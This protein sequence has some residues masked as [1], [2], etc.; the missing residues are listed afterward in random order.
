MLR[1]RLYAQDPVCARRLHACAGSWFETE[2]GESELFEAMRHYLA[3]RDWELAAELL[4]CHSIRFVQSG[5]LG[6][7]A[8]EWLARFPAAVVQADARLCHVSA[9][10]AALD[11]DRERRDGWL[12]TGER[13]GWEGP[14]PDGTASYEM[15]SGCLA[16]MLCFDDLGGAVHAAQAPL[17]ALPLRAPMRTAV[18]TMTAWHLHLLGD[19]D[20]AELLARRALAEQAHLPSAGLP[21]VA[22]LPRAVLS[23]AALRRGQPDQARALLREAVRQ[24]DDGPLRSSP[25]TLPVVYA[26]ARLQTHTGRPGDAIATCRAGLELARGWRDSSL[27]VPAV[28]LEQARA[29]AALADAH[30]AAAAAAAARARLA[31]ARDAG[32]LADALEAVAPASEPGGLQALSSREV[33]VLRALS[34]PGSLRQL[35]DELFVSRNTVKTHT[36]AL[37]AKLGVGSRDEAVARGR[38][39]GLLDPNALSGCLSEDRR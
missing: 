12:A 14:M 3:A 17:A 9:L 27:M 7:R 32:A 4:S 37:Y 13:A 18:E 19:D 5:A 31:G 30:G 11:G 6:G 28:L 24:R 16:A 23:L 8:R 38:Q 25:H 15:A 1:N 35:A 29:H 20:A 34:R 21:L 2:G 39:A 36:R 10:L 33:E 22:Y 26:Q